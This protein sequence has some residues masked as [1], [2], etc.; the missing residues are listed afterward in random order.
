M[1]DAL[2]LEKIFDEECHKKRTLA[3]AGE[4]RRGAIRGTMSPWTIQAKKKPNYQDS[5][6]HNQYKAELQRRDG[7]LDEL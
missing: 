1:D 5:V 2:E 6:A 3:H 4:A 7:L